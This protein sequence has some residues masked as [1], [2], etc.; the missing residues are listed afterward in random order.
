MTLAYYDDEQNEFLI[1]DVRDWIR[2][3]DLIV[4]IHE[5]EHFIVIGKSSFELPNVITIFVAPSKIC[6]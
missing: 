1:S 2:R 5:V 4:G 3:E 6:H